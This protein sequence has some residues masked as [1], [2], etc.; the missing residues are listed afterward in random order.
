M[1]IPR[2]ELLQ[3]VSRGPL[4]SVYIVRDRLNGQNMLL[5]TL[6]P[7][8]ANDPE[9]TKRFLREAEMIR[10][11]N[12][13]NIVKIYDHGSY[14]NVPFTVMEYV[15]GWNLRDFEN[16]NRPLPFTIAL[17]VFNKILDALAYAHKNDIIHRDIK[18]SNILVG[19]DGS[20]KLTDFGLARPQ[21]LS[22]ITEHGNMIGT[23]AYIAPEILQGQPSSVKSD[24]FSAGLTF[25]EVLTG[26][27]PFKGERIAV[28]IHNIMNKTLPS[29]HDYR[30]DIPRWLDLLIKKMTC[31]DVAQRIESVD[32]I[33]RDIKEHTAGLNLPDLAKFTQERINDIID[34]P[35]LNHGG[36]RTGGGRKKVGIMILALISVVFVFYWAEMRFPNHVTD[37]DSRPENSSAEN[38][39]IL[40]SSRGDEPLQPVT[41]VQPPYVL[42][43]M[44]PESPVS[45]I[46]E[47]PPDLGDISH[48]MKM[49]GLFI[50][51]VPWA[52]IKINGA[53]QDT[54][55]MSDPINLPA[56]EYQVTVENPSY[57]VYERSLT[58]NA[59]QIDSLYIILDEKY[60]YLDVSVVPWGEIYL[61]D[62]F[63]ETTPIKSPVRIEGGHYLLTVKNP[64]FKPYEQEIEI[65]P[66][67]TA[68]I[69]VYLE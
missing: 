47:N 2:Y 63:V 31:K 20:V 57:N 56:G 62:N 45:Q 42:R 18:P 3:E 29:L 17:P 38:P 37:A 40:D 39:S 66:G 32:R 34:L 15:K 54:T 49:G 28:T 26:E 44:T 19:A 22:A 68:E 16:L 69:V 9:I 21:D 25:F 4:T 50:V 6:N 5:K 13:Q 41:Y 11:F 23:P 7:Q 65:R 46:K 30:S 58:V 43:E 35:S 24:I 33:C 53:A 55:P 27:N 61:D 67:E 60:G 36:Q 48:D 12:H 8:H 10:R 59:G 1:Q 64:Y 52:Y 14:K 51:A